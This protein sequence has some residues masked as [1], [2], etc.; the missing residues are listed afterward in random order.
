MESA[1]LFSE[2]HAGCFDQGSDFFPDLD[3]QF[4]HSLRTNER[5][6]DIA[7]SN[8]NFDL[9]HHHALFNVNDLTLN[10]VPSNL[11]SF[12]T[13]LLFGLNSGKWM[14]RCR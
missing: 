4:F 14:G 3:A 7:A 12:D 8:V 6:N 10:N 2:H 5:G 9:S 1:L 11:V 13:F